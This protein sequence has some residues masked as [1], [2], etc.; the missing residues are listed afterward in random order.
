MH[1]GFTEDLLDSMI[2]AVYRRLGSRET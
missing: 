1:R 2:V